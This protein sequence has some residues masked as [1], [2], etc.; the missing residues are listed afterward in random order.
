M[1]NRIKSIYRN[2]QKMFHNIMGT[3]IIKSVSLLLNIYSITAYLHYFD[4]NQ[5]LY[6]VWLTI[7]SILNWVVNFDLGIGNGLRNKLAA[8]IA[9]QDKDKEKTLISS[10]YILV[11]IVSAGVFL[12]ALVFSLC[13]NWNK[14]LNVDTEIISNKTLCKAVIFSL[15]GLCL[16]FI[17]KLIISVLY[18]LKETALGSLITLLMN[19]LIILYSMMFQNSDADKAIIN[20]SV[21]YAF[22]MVVPLI[23]LTIYV[24]VFKMPHSRPSLKY[25]N[26][27][28]AASILSL[29][30]QFFLVQILLLFIN[31]T[32][33]F[34][35]ARIENPEAVVTYNIYF[36][37]FSAIIAL[38]AVII[39]PVWSSISVSFAKK[40]YK[41]IRWRKKAITVIA[42]ILS[43]GS[44]ILSALLQIFVNLMYES[45]HLIVIKRY[46][47]LFA[48]YTSI[49][50]FVNAVSC[51]EN[52]INDLRPQ[53][54]GNTVAALLK[55]PVVWIAYLIV[56]NWVAV[57]YA[58]IVIM[59]ISLVIQKIGMERK[60]KSIE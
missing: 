7:I 14:L 60:L 33:E 5:K 19:I 47:I 18:A 55:I 29:G 57:V 39:N 1:L 26:H 50:L 8:A 41:G 37:L 30:G 20:V 58:N 22:T 45:S 28:F 46:A 54:I 9:I 13:I 12:L 3:F 24:F 25:Y 56:R 53:M 21:V 31:A 49:M 10:A 6:G 23:V 51:I 2:D 4:G 34:L 27:K 16:H 44:F 40:D 15:F 59:L 17:F 38:F 42:I 36:R 32:N 11:S 48:L 43:I 35:I 52:G